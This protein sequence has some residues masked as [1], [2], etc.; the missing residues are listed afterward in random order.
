M[1]STVQYS[2][3]LYE[4]AINV[5]AVT[6]EFWNTNAAGLAAWL[7]EATEINSVEAMQKKFDW[8]CYRN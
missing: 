3:H 5:P 8:A 4:M 2:Q 7:V 1:V 6:R